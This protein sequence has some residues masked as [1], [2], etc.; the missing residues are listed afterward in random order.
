M[1]AAIVATAALHAVAEGVASIEIGARLEP[2][3][4]QHLIDR[5][6]G[7]AL[8]LH[9]LVPREIVF[10]EAAPWEGNYGGYHSGDSFRSYYRGGQRL[11]NVRNKFTHMVTCVTES[12]DGIHW[13]RPQSDGGG[14]VGGRQHPHRDPGRDRPSD[15]RLCVRGFRGAVRRRD[16][17]GTAM[18]L[19]HENYHR[20]RGA[21]RRSQGGP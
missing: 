4:D 6:D 5:F 7:A 9:S 17:G 13:K 14:D 18:P 15:S 2:F 21:D 20:W 1:T 16:R 3:F 11:P 10:H 8:K 19:R 12:T